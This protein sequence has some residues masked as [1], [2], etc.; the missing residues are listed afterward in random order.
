MT[1][2]EVTAAELERI[3]QA[4]DGKLT[5]SAVLS[6]A[7]AEDNPI[8]D[9]FEWDD[10]KAGHEYRLMQ[11]RQLIRLQRV[12]T[13]DGADEPTYVHIRTVEADT[14][15]G[16]YRPIEQVARTARRVAP[17]DG[18]RGQAG[19]VGAGSGGRPPA[20]FT[21]EGAQQDA[22]ADHHGL[23]GP[24]SSVGRIGAG[25]LLGKA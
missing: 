20:A 6:A 11:A 2:E 13:E 22:G 9:R 8:H 24:W 10:S 1:L 15:E 7:E 19:A 17:G 16:Y 12:T 23:E 4:H 25:G 18:R 3:R 5:A 14:R 21:G